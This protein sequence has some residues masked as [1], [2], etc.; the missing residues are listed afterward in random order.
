MEQ[1][2]ILTAP[3]VQEDVPDPRTSSAFHLT[4]AV[5]DVCAFEIFFT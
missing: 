4:E 1:I 3:Q 5:I 2:T